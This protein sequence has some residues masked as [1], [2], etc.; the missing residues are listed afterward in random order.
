[1][2]KEQ[3]IVYE[4]FQLINALKENFDQYYYTHNIYHFYVKNETLTYST[5]FF[6]NNLL[7]KNQADRIWYDQQY[8]FGLNPLCNWIIMYTTGLYEN[9]ANWNL[10]KNHFGISD[11][12]M[13]GLFGK[14]SKMYELFIIIQSSNKKINYNEIIIVGLVKDKF[15]KATDLYKAQWANFISNDPLVPVKKIFLFYNNYL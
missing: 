6:R 3:S 10:I 13:E 9:H 1:M 11:A 4:I 5:I 14:K 15:S 7:S 8:G 12:Q 2:R